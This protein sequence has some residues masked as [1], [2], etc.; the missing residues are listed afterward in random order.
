MHYLKSSLLNQLDFKILTP[1][2]HSQEWRLTSLRMSSCKNGRKGICRNICR[3]GICLNEDK[4][5]VNLSLVT[6]QLVKVGQIN[7]SFS[8]IGI[9]HHL[10]QKIV[11][12]MNTGNVKYP[13]SKIV[14]KNI[15][16]PLKQHFLDAKHFC[17]VLFHN[18]LNLQKSFKY[19]PHFS[20]LK[21]LNN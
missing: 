20:I 8:K 14:P 17:Q 3:K 6:P 2:S 19:F 1:S 18:V 15:Y 13:T 11:W 9:N 4:S 21:R 7:F 5:K 16:I 12:R 10:P